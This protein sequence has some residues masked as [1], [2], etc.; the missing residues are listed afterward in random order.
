VMADAIM[1]SKDATFFEDIV[2]MRDMQ[3]ILDTNLRR[4]LNIPF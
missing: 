2:S 3:N 1:E 4:L